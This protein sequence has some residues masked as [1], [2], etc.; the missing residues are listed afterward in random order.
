M[1][2]DLVADG[3]VARI[4]TRGR[5]SGRARPV[6]VGFV[7]EP[8]GSLLVAARSEST[9]WARNLAADPACR[10]VVGERQ[11]DAVAEPLSRDDHIRAIRALILRYGTPSEDLGRGPSFRLRR[12]VLA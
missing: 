10:V 11:F 9:A 5:V 2:D 3:R 8:D 1:E 7:T 12:V 6:S 4:E